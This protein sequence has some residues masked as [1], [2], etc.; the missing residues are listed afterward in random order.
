ML[1]IA[2][3]PNNA[4]SRR[5][6]SVAWFGK[7]F[8]DLEFCTLFILPPIISW[9]PFSGDPKTTST[10]SS[11]VVYFSNWSFVAILPFRDVIIT[12]PFHSDSKENKLESFFNFVPP[13]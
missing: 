5:T 10:G 6:V 9:T 2:S 11:D 7:K 1:S 13:I 4:S 8:K 3:V 12:L